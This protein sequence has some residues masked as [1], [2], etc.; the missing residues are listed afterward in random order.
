MTPTRS[1]V[2][3]PGSATTIR[4]PGP[5][6]AAPRSPPKRAS[7]S[8][9][10]TTLTVASGSDKIRHNWSR[11]PLNAR[12]GPTHHPNDLENLPARP[13]GQP[14]H[15]PIQV[16]TLFNVMKPAPKSPHHHHHSTSQR[17]APQSAG[18]APRAPA[19]SPPET[20]DKPYAGSPP[21][22]PP[23]PTNSPHRLEHTHAHS[24]T[25]DTQ[26]FTTPASAI[27]PAG[28]D[29][30]RP[31]PGTGRYNAPGITTIHK[32]PVRILWHA[33][34][35]LNTSLFEPMQLAV[36]IRCSQRAFECRCCAVLLRP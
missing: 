18:P 10:T 11:L 30:R 8:R 3:A 1:S 36:T 29:S 31:Q 33:R 4:R 14:S 32:G 28:L 13:P 34:I 24:N 16:I 25:L 15:P 27:H 6:N 21:P 5:L 26:Q 23:N 12:P 2:P 19:T 22:N 35:R 7:R 9:C 17:Y 20:S